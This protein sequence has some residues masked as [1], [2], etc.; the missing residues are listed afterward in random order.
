MR[1]GPVDFLHK[2]L[3]PQ[4]LLTTVRAALEKASLVRSNS[5]RLSAL[6]P[7]EREILE[8]LIE[9]KS[10]KMI[11]ADTGLSLKT[12]ENHRMHLLAKTGAENTPDLVR[13]AMVAGVTRAA[14]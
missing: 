7:R 5:A 4:V 10:S 9:G 14:G 12:V 11:A 2:P 3:D 1:L 8:M 6:T 13:L